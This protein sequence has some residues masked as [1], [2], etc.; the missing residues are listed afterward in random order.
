MSLFSVLRTL[1]LGTKLRSRQ[2]QAAVL[3]IASLAMGAVV[4]FLVRSLVDSVAGGNAGFAVWALG[5]LIAVVVRAVL[6]FSALFSWHVLRHEAIQLFRLAMFRS[7]LRK[8]FTFFTA[9]STGDLMARVLEDVKIPAQHVATGIL[10]GVIN[11]IHLLI[12]IGVLV[13]LE[14][15]LALI[16]L[17]SVPAYYIAFTAFNRRL[18]ATIGRERTEYGC[19]STDLQEAITGIRVI[20]IFHREGYIAEKFGERLNQYLATVR[21]YVRSEA[22]AST[23]TTFISQLVP[24]AVLIYG[25]FLVNDGQ[26]T[27]GSLIAFYSYIEQLYGPVQNL[28]D[29]NI[30]RQQ[31]VGSLPRIAGLIAPEP[32][33]GGGVRI[34]TIENLEL[35]DVSLFYPSG[36]LPALNRVSLR[37]SRGERVGIAGASGSGK[38][39][40]LNVLL[41]LYR[42]T[43]GHVRINGVEIEAVD[44]A[45]FH[46]RIGFVDQHNFIFS[47][48]IE[49]NIRMGRTEGRAVDEVAEIA[50]ISRFIAAQPQGY[51]TPVAELGATLSGGQ[52]QRL[53]IARA[54]LG[55]PAVLVLDEATSALDNETEIRLIEALDEFLAGRTLIAVSHRPAILEACDYV[56]FMSGGT[57]A[58][59]GPYSELVVTQP[60]FRQLV[61][62]EAGQEAG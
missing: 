21:E 57:V 61:Q 52:R 9:G 15:R 11:S 13:A 16:A 43:S 37:I 49:E 23:A 38:T 4:P 41:G 3:G 44:L 12:V 33:R 56:V 42:P 35:E 2:V 7:F 18:R 39:S 48:T 55:D 30:A 40:L 28:S 19:M 20:Q 46:G 22:L 10:M 36:T 6:N 29:F 32:E 14:P 47:G 54:L 50:Q 24:A 62:A 17:L 25:V 51:Q 58:A 8:P 60:E 5:L 59:I 26:T 27:I 53:C 1:P 45:S 31:A 34:D